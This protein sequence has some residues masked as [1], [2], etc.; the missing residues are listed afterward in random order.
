MLVDIPILS[1]NLAASEA[2]L[3]ALNGSSTIP[4]PAIAVCFK[5]SRREVF[6]MYILM[7]D[8]YNKGSDCN[9]ELYIYISKIR[10]IR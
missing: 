5:K 1:R 4:V 6:M 7:F 8:H 3:N 9:Q 10:Y 2:M